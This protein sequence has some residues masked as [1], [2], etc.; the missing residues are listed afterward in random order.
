MS[1]NL[2]D[3]RSPFEAYCGC[4]RRSVTFDLVHTR[5]FWATAALTHTPNWQCLAEISLCIRVNL[6]DF[7]SEM[8]TSVGGIIGMCGYLMIGI[9]CP[10]NGMPNT[11]RKA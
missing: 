8:P 3:S 2:S 9:R 11:T 6:L 4:H 5:Q 7:G 10:V 1:V